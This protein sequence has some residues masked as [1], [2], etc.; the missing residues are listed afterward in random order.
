MP[1]PE[2]SPEQPKSL[3]QRVS[4]LETIVAALTSL[5]AKTVEAHIT[6]ENGIGTQLDSLQ[7]S[8]LSLHRFVGAQMGFNAEVLGNISHLEQSQEK[9]PT[10]TVEETANETSSSRRNTG[11]TEK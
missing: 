8:V 2:N 10:G 3:E 11:S 7:E 5:V 6:E 9:T 4:D 1:T